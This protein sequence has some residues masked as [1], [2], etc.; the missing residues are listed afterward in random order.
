MYPIAPI[1]EMLTSAGLISEGQVQTAL[2]DQRFYEDMRLGEIFVSRGWLRQETVD[3][4]CDVLQ[5]D[6]LDTSRFL[7]GES[8]LQAALLD[9][10][11]VKQILQEQRMNHVRFGALA[12]LKGY[13]SQRT[14]DFFLKHLYAV[15]ADQ[16]DYLQKNLRVAK[17]T[18]NQNYKSTRLQKDRKSVV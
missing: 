5:R 17:Q 6:D 15:R 12:V 13:I 9:R 2:Y 7:L 14:L 10:Q 1:G 4:F 3:F 11:Q 18:L 16:N 8:L